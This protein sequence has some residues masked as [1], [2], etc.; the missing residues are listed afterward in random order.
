MEALLYCCCGLDVH[1]DMI[2]AC[3]LKG[4]PDVEPEI[5]R[6]QFTTYQQGLTELVEWLEKN[7]CYSVAMESTGVYWMPVFEKLETN[8]KYLENLWVVNAYHMRNLP[9]RKSDIKDAEW[10]ATLLRHGLLEKSFVPPLMTRELREYTRLNRTFV[11]EES[12]YVN[13]VEKFL[14]YHGFKFSSVMKNIVGATG[15]SLLK[16]LIANG[17]ITESDVEKQCK[18]LRK[19]PIEEIKSAVVGKL[20]APEQKLL[21]HLVHKIEESRA[22]I[23]NL[24]KDMEPLKANIQRSLEIADSIPGIDIDSACEI[25]AEISDQPHEHFQDVGRICSW[26][27]LTPKN[28]ESAGKI[29]S[30]KMR[31]GNQHVKSI[32]C[33]TAWAAVRC[34]KSSFHDWFWKHRNKIGQKKAIMAVARKILALLYLLLKKNTLYLYPAPA[35]A[36]APAPAPA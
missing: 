15:I 12:R 1:R 7:E 14:Q 33:Q 21:A 2:E 34:R 29:K 28:D 11:Q 24:K 18:R 5:T 31:H 13:R 26:A 16:T 19:H 17:E 10:I 36:T 9:G 30:R 23:A 3:I 8:S 27:G 4:N 6:Q 25:L 32:L 22:D 35:P 20:D